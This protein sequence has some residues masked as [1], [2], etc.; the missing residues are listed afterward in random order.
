M[1]FVCFCRANLISTAK[2]PLTRLSGVVTI[3]R[4]F[5]SAHSAGAEFLTVLIDKLSLMSFYRKLER[6]GGYLFYRRE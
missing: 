4:L 2:L 1:S 6:E 5:T 3:A